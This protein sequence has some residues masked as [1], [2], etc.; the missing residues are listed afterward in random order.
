MT[1]AAATAT[2]IGMTTTSAAQRETATTHDAQ[3]QRDT[4]GRAPEGGSA[5]GYNIQAPLWCDDREEE[6]KGDT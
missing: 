4:Q 1:A 5:D 2:T 3:W 6:K